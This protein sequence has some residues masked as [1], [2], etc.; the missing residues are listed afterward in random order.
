MPQLLYAST[1]CIFLIYLY[2][3]DNSQSILLN[4]R[5][6]TYILHASFWIIYLYLFEFIVY[7]TFEKYF[8]QN[9]QN[10]I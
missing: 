5:S 10:R 8:F 4:E 2:E 3:R 9:V 7:S 6:K 1:S